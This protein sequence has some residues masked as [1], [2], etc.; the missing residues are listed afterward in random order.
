MEALGWGTFNFHQMRS[1]WKHP[2]QLSRA[3]VN[4]M[5]W[6]KTQSEEETEGDLKSAYERARTSRGKVSNIFKA[7]SLDPKSLGAHL[8]LYLSILF[9]GGKSSRKQREMIAVIVSAQNGCQYC[10]AHHSAALGRYVKEEGFIA[11]L[12]ENPL[13]VALPAKDRAMVEYAITLTRNPKS[14]TE[15]DINELRKQGLVD[16]EILNLALV[17]AYFNFVNRLASGLGVELEDEGQTQYRY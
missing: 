17:A 14:L 15:K 12:I 8:D 16:E 4:S 11:K 5:T 6:K 13:V 9:G 2:V 3:Q 7:Q 1:A 10:V